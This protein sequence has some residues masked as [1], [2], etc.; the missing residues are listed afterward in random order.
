M[1]WALAEYKPGRQQKIMFYNTVQRHWWGKKEKSFLLLL[2][3]FHLEE[4]MKRSWPSLQPLAH[5]WAGHLLTYLI[6][7][8]RI[9]SLTG[10]LWHVQFSSVLFCLLGESAHSI[11]LFLTVDF[12]EVP[13][14]PRGRRRCSFPPLLKTGGEVSAS[15]SGLH[16]WEAHLAL[17]RSYSFQLCIYE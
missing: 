8:S 4:A 1:Y 7:E 9:N 10:K 15:N 6:D 17:S 11:L 3:S 13:S 2:T 5:F 14:L 16:G 12:T